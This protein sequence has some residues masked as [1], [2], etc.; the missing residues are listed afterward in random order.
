MMSSAKGSEEGIPL[1]RF[2]LLNPADCPFPEKGLD[3]DFLFQCKTL[4]FVYWNWG[5]NVR[6]R[7]LAKEPP[8]EFEKSWAC[9]DGLRLVVND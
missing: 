7:E 5:W 6:L 9:P 2:L 8:E 3:L 1:P 4:L